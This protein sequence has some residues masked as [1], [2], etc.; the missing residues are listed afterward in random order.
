MTNT[1][2]AASLDWAYDE[3]M[4]LHSAGAIDGSPYATIEVGKS[5]EAYA[6]I[7]GLG[8][9]EYASLGE[10]KKAAARSWASLQARLA[11]AGNGLCWVLDR[12]DERWVGLDRDGR[13]FASA[14]RDQDVPAGY[15]NTYSTAIRGENGKFDTGYASRLADF[16]AAA[17]RAYAAAGA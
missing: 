3:V 13:K 15:F 4:E 7:F 8:E 6:T 10:A 11:A 17:G 1:A 16:K 12:E 2:R 5:G 14:R 9:R